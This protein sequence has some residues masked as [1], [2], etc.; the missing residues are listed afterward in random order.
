VIAPA[1][2]VALLTVGMNTFTDAV[3]RV[4]SGIEGGR[5]KRRQVRRD[6]RILGSVG[7]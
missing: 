5:R 7:P 3:A 1:I 6:A 2:L 4:A